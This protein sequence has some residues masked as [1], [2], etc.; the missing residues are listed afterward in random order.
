[1]HKRT[2]GFYSEVNFPR[3]CGL[4][5]NGLLVAKHRRELVS[6]VDGD[7]RKIGFGVGLNLACYPE[8]Q[9]KITVVEA[10]PATSVTRFGRISHKL[11]YRSSEVSLLVV[12]DQSIL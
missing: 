6:T 2:V 8:H 4:I 7:I 3:R 5:L 10:N 9:H 11:F 1:M 12:T